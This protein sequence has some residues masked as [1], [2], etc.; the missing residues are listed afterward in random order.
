VV[1]LYAVRLFLEVF[2]SIWVILALFLLYE[3]EKKKLA[4]YAQKRF[5][6][7]LTTL[8]D[9]CMPPGR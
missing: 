1:F 3:E 2:N 7:F 5:N 6:G 4:R 9:E 8:Y